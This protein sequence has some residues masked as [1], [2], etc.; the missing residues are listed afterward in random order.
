M[1]KKLYLPIMLV[2]MFAMLLGA[3]APA[4][5]PTAE[6]VV[7]APVV[8]EEP[9]AVPT[10]EPVVEEIDYEALFTE[11]VANN[12]ADKG[13]NGI[14]AD[15]LNT[16]LVENPDLFILD[17]RQPAEYEA[18]GYIDTVNL[19]AIP[20]RDLMDNLDK[21]P[22]L[23]DPIVIYCKGGHRGAVAMAA[24]Q[25]VGYTNVRNLLN[26]INAWN[27]AEL[28]AIKGVPPAPEAISTPV[29]ADEKLFTAVRDYIASLPDGF[30]AISAAQLN[31]LIVN[32]DEFTLVDVRPQSD[33]DAGH[34]ENAILI[35]FSD[36]MTSLDL[37]PAKD[38]K[39]VLYCGSGHRGGILL[40]A[41]QLM[42]Y[43]DV[44]NLNGGLGAWKTAELPVVTP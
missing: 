4:A 19:A 10:P 32:G 33:F 6:P 17:V 43:T 29:V 7:E 36:F 22:G 23:D 13:F 5:T 3:C 15:K 21:L 40:V 27:K 18:D 37:L 11:V 26:G 20:L 31:E 8:V 35:P 44:V 34:I 28:P 38:A 41:M 1:S 2:V 12:P 39:I 24:L 9:T 25:A 30:A 14:S 16:E 42:G